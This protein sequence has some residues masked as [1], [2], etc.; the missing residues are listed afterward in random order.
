[1]A[2]REL[3]KHLEN[4]PKDELIKIIGELYNLNK[5][6]KEFCENKF[7]PDSEGKLQLYKQKVK[8]AFFPKRGYQLKL[9]DA[10][11]AISDFKKLSPSAEQLCDI[12]LYYTEMGVDF[13]NEYGD[14]DE[15]FY[16]SL[17]NNYEKALELMSKNKLLAVFQERC[18]A[19]VSN[20]I[21]MGWGFHDT[22]SDI[23]SENFE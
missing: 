5:Q 16:T 23:Y 19:V 13:T 15:N 18:E 1:M 20:T 9:S 10:R 11:K 14:I 22:L 3:K 2:L 12:L 7:N 6:N 8:E 21:D 17:E 4:L